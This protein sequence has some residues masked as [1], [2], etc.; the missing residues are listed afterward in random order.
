M[1]STSSKGFLLKRLPSSIQTHM[2]FNSMV[3]HPS[4]PDGTYHYHWLG[5][6]EPEPNWATDPRWIPLGWGFLW[7]VGLWIF[8][9]D[10]AANQNPGDCS[11]QRGEPD[12]IDCHSIYTYI[13]HLGMVSLPPIC[14]IYII[15]YVY[16]GTWG[17]SMS[18][19]HWLYHVTLQRTRPCFNFE[20]WID[21]SLLMR[22]LSPA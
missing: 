12:A 17:W 21:D 6:T 10:E 3:E 20:P 15:L 1:L 13:Y 18:P 4:R 19:W 16:I 22:F 14:G 8:A 7:G 9:Q 5:W 11:G 2:C